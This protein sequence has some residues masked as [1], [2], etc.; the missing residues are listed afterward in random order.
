MHVFPAIPCDFLHTYAMRT[1]VRIRKWES[2]PRY[3]FTAN[4]RQ[5]G[6]RIVRYFKTEKEARAFAAEK[7]VELLNEGRRNGEITAE[8]RRAMMVA[9]EKG[10]SLKD[11]VDHYASHLGALNQSVT[12]EV[13][14]QELLSIRQA[15]G[16]SKGHLHDLLYRLRRFARDHGEQ[17][18]AS[19]TTRDIDRWLASLVCAPQTRVNY[20]RVIHNFF[21]FCA[22]RGYCAGNPVT[23]ASKVKVPP[24]E[25]GI[26]SP[27]EAQALLSGC[28]KE[29]LP[30]VAIGMFAGLRREEIARLD[31]RS[32]D[33]DRK[34]I[35][36]AAAKSKTAQRRLVTVSDNLHAWLAPYRAI[37]EP[38]RLPEPAYRRRFSKALKASKIESWPKNALRHSYASYHLAA[39]Q[40][41]A[42][43]ALQ[44]GHTESRT[45]FA[46]YR[47]LV[48]PEDAKAYWKIFPS[49]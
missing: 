21:S 3:K 14:T 8:E 33:L 29:I 18:A 38:V 42:K 27:G 16:K 15:E 11:A 44:L 17:L 40:D 36:V 30:A 49:N 2:Q 41:A 7:Q 26:L 47:E 20:R 31:W 34:F 1:L 22:A 32:I 4:Y 23:Q 35:E 5:G 43:T 45:L 46:H 19:L 13:A 6:K 24:K 9:R 39:H 12:V 48:K 10:F 25:I 37:S 28:P